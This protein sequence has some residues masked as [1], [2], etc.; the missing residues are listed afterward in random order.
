MQLTVL[1]ATPQKRRFFL[2]GQKSDTKD[3]NS[4]TFGA[5]Q[6]FELEAGSSDYTAYC[7]SLQLVARSLIPSAQHQTV[8]VEVVSGTSWVFQLDSNNAP[9]LL[10]EKGGHS[11]LAEISCDNQSPG[12]AVVGLYSNYATLYAHQALSNQRTTFVAG[13]LY[14]YA[15]V[16]VVDEQQPIVFEPHIGTL[17]L[18]GASEITARFVQ[19]NDVFQWTF[20]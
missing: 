20:G 8:Q 16:A 14:F 19:D 5:W 3:V 18:S 7:Q 9:T 6:S 4:I 2:L 1:N 12:I 10:A 15:T 11:G 17:D 13:P